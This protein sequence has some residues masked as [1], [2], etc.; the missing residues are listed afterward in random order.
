MAMA[1]VKKNSVETMLANLT[2]NNREFW[3]SF[4]ETLTE[5]TRKVYQSDILNYLVWINKDV[6]ETNASEFEKYAFSLRENG[7]GNKAINKKLSALRSF[8]KFLMKD[9]IMKENPLLSV[10]YLDQSEVVIEKNVL[11]W[12]LIQDC[13]TLDGVMGNIFNSVYGKGLS[14]EDAAKD[15][16]ISVSKLQYQIKKLGEYVGISTL[17][18]MD[19]IETRNK[20]FAKCPECGEYHE[21]S[22]ENWKFKNGLMV[23]KNC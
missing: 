14:L 19:L 5:S 4:S 10:Q 7:V 8:I 23:C 15:S 6:T 3:L 16:E 2:E 21:M 18:Y 17:K 12:E 1:T 13:K 11:S 22:Q 20:F 9:E